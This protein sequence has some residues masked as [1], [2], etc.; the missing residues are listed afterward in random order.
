[1]I[2]IAVMRF[3]G[4]ELMVTLFYLNRADGHSRSMCK[5]RWSHRKI[6][7]EQLRLGLVLEPARGST[8]GQLPL[9]HISNTSNHGYPVEQAPKRPLKKHLNQIQPMQAGQMDLSLIQN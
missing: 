5:D 2:H 6:Q 9:D 1:M 4:M 8:G 7:R 3:K